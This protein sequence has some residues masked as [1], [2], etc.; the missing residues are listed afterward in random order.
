MLISSYF[1]SMNIVSYLG[2]YNQRN[3]TKRN[4]FF[5]P[6]LSRE[7]WVCLVNVRRSIAWRRSQEAAAVPGTSRVD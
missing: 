6:L 4:E 7:I 5:G 1:I 3:E 2:N